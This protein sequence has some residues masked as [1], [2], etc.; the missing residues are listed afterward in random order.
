MIKKIEEKEKAW[1]LGNAFSQKGSSL[2]STTEAMSPLQGQTQTPQPHPT[3]RISMHSPAAYPN[4]FPSVITPGL[5]LPRRQPLY[6][7]QFTQ[8][9]P[10]SSLTTTSTSLPSLRTP[11]TTPRRSR[12]ARPG[13]LTRTELLGY[14]SRPLRW[15]SPLTLTTFPSISPPSSFSQSGSRSTK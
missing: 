14:P 13:T 12:L 15:L 6:S 7:W 5:R 3:P 4:P 2:R 9:R 1:D 11:S 10:M 8:S